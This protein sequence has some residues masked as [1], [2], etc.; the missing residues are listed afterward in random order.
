MKLKK[1]L[2][3]NELTIFVSLTLKGSIDFHINTYI[4][5]VEGIS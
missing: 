4:I 1:I 2:K 3:F 5:D